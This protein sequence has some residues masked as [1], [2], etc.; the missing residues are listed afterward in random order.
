MTM[1]LAIAT[2][3]AGIVAINAKIAVLQEEA[4][5]ERAKSIEPF[6]EAL[7]ASGE[8]S[9]IVIRGYTP[10]FNDGEPCEHS[11]DVFV[12]VGELRDNE[13]LEQAG[14]FDFEIPEEIETILGEMGYSLSDE[15]K[16]Q[17][18]ALCAQH[19]HVWDQPS[20]EILDGINSLLFDTAEEE[21][22][23]DYY[24]TYI[25]ENGKFV[26]KSGEYDCGY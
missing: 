23:T 3:T 12:N 10:G 24:V 26:K 13:I 25:L 8:V 15:E 19:G 1:Q 2:A 14:E 7:A 5:A 17:A 6:L 18:K 11:A 9:V 22:G 16:E 20:K 4:R 21:E